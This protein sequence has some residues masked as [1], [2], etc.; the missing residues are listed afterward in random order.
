MPVIREEMHAQTWEYFRFLESE[1][2]I[3]LSDDF[4]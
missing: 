3:A 2:D 4:L 1:S